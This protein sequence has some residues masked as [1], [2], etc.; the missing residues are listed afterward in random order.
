MVADIKAGGQ[1]APFYFRDLMGVLV[2]AA[3]RAA[4]IKLRGERRQDADGNVLRSGTLDSDV[5]LAEQDDVL[6]DAR[7][8]G[9]D[10]KFVMAVQLFSDAALVSWSGGALQAP[11]SSACTLLGFFCCCSEDHDDAEPATTPAGHVRQH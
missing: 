5:F 10:K 2:D 7:H 6:S 3:Q 9:I 11:F 8:S 4:S 1:T